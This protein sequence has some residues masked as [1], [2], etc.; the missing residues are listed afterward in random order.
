MKIPFELLSGI[1]LIDF[2]IFGGSS[3]YL[4]EKDFFDL[5]GFKINSYFYINNQFL[6]R[7][8]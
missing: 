2:T 3:S 7:P 8:S 6:S 1:I 5:C 4:F